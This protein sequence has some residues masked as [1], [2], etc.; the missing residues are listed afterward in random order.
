MGACCISIRAMAT[1]CFCPPDRVTPRSPT[2][3]SYPWGKAEMASSTQA[4]AA[5][6]RMASSPASGRTAQMFSPTVWENRKG[7]WSTRP[8][9]RRRDSRFMRRM[10]TPPMVMEPPP[11]GRSYSR[12]SRCTKVLLPEPVPPRMAKVSPW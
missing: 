3:V 9:W 11:S 4:T 5:A 8:I 1:R 10:S 2:T 12:S 6:R 7:S